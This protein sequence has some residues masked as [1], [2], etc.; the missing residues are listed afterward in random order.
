MASL[1]ASYVWQ[2]RGTRRECV[3]SEQDC[4]LLIDNM[5]EKDEGIYKC[6]ASEN[7]YDRMIVLQ[8]LY[9][10]GASETRGTPVAL[11]CLLFL[12]ILHLLRI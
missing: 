4:I 6:V 5:S 7:G 2:H 9:M 3:S 8:E 12:S 11:A 10:N 1:H